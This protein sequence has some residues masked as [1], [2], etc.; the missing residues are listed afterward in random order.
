MN[1][2]TTRPWPKIVAVLPIADHSAQVIFMRT[3]T[4]GEFAAFREFVETDEACP[5]ENI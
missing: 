5:V 4:D 1:D 3:P 2:N